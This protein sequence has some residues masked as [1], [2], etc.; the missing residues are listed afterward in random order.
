MVLVKREREI[1]RAQNGEERGNLP[2]QLVI[3]VF[4]GLEREGDLRDRRNPKP[5]TQRKR[6]IGSSRN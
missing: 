3:L 4:G 5:L 6:R 2:G 1:E